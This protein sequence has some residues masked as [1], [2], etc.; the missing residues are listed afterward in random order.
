M[1]F[2]FTCCIENSVEVFFNICRL[3]TQTPLH[4][5]YG[6]FNPQTRYLLINMQLQDIARPWLRLNYT[7]LTSSVVLLGCYL[8]Q[9]A[10]FKSS[11]H[12]KASKW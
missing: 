10:R 4:I 8:R 11:G 1:V 9:Q 6:S 7:C 5:M 12:I 3:F 2:D